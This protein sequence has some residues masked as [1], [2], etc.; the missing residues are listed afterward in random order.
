MRNIYFLKSDCTMYTCIPRCL[1]KV[2]F[3]I[4]SFRGS[5]ICKCPFDF[6]RDSKVVSGMY[7]NLFNNAVL[8]LSDKKNH[9]SSRRDIGIGSFDTFLSWSAFLTISQICRSFG[10]DSSRT[11]CPI[12]R[13]S[14]SI[15]HELLGARVKEP[16]GY[17][18]ENIDYNHKWTSHV[19]W[20]CEV[21]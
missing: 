10:N 3:E 20:K 14:S 9:S 2:K 19:L 18:M 13:N 15:V 7:G 12:A 8:A 6:I 5:T 21:V 16:S 17:A 4:N 11:L 1:R